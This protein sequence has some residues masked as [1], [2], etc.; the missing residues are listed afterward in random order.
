MPW[1]DRLR[2]CLLGE[3]ILNKVKIRAQAL[4]DLGAAAGAADSQSLHL[5]SKGLADPKAGGAV[6]LLP[7]SVVRPAFG[8]GE[9]ET[10]SR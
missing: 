8:S 7:S 3:H 1:Q 4:P 5:L 6:D 10:G 9:P 2:F